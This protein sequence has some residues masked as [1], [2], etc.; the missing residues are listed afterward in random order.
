[1]QLL[2][3]FAPG[4]KGKSKP[5]LKAEKDFSWCVIERKSYRKIHL[6]MMQQAEAQKA[7][8]IIPFQ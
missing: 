4:Q 2:F 7:R 5:S 1:V 8:R 6:Q 3:S